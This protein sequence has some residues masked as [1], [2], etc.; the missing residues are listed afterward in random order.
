MLFFLSS[1]EEVEDVVVE[2]SRHECPDKPACRKVFHLVWEIAV[3]VS[4]YDR[5]LI[6]LGSEI[7]PI[8]GM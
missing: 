1:E 5:D 2:V 6:P 4:V 3:W 8:V 7:W